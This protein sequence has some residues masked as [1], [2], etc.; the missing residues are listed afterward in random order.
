MMEN[1]S[2]AHII[3]VALQLFHEKG[4]NNVSL[5][6]VIK[7]SG[8]SKGAFYHHFSSKREL[9]IASV[10]SYWHNMSNEILNAPIDQMTVKEVFEMITE[11]MDRIFHQL[12]EGNENFFELYISMLSFVREEAEILKISRNYFNTFQE[13]LITSIKKD[14]DKGILNPAIP[15]KNSALL[16]TTCAEGHGLL[17]FAQIH[18]KPTENL[19]TIFNQIYNSLVL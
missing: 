15:A 13:K 18:E 9:T 8:L 10:I 2:K 1:D 11:Q 7:A 17:S 3:Q 4:M 12:D 5:N 19:R 6:E 14:Q 16:I